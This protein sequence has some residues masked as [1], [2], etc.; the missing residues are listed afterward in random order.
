M[1]SKQKKKNP[2]IPAL[3]LCPKSWGNKVSYRILSSL[4]DEVLD[5]SQDQLI[6]Q[7]CNPDHY[8]AITFVDSGLQNSGVLSQGMSWKPE[9]SKGQLSYINFASLSC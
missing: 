1:A 8:V 9:G 7:L 3:C 6:A 2:A 5:I 4:E